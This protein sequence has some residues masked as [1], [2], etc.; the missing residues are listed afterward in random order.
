MV[1]HYQRVWELNPTE[2]WDGINPPTRGASCWKSPEVTGWC[3]ERVETPNFLRHFSAKPVATTEVKAGPWRL[4]RGSWVLFWICWDGLGNDGTCP[5]KAW[6]NRLN[7]PGLLWNL[8]G[9]ID[10]WWFMLFFFH[11]RWGRSGGWMATPF[12]VE[13]YLSQD[14]TGLDTSTCGGMQQEVRMT[15]STQLVNKH[16]YGK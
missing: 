5:E 8:F 13:V 12:P 3:M 16:S 7:F 15:V 11:L 1:G 2:A 14:W 4:P 6:N 9:N 10:I